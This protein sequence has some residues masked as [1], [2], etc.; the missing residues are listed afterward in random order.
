MSEALA[1]RDDQIALLQQCLRLINQL[2][3]EQYTHTNAPLYNS[4]I[5]PHLRHCIEHY[6]SFCNAWSSGQIN[7]DHRARSGD[8]ESTPSAA[9]DAIYSIIDALQKLQKDDLDQ[10]IKT[11][12]DCGTTGE[13]NFSLS[14]VRRELQF[15]TSHTVHHYALIAM[16]L[17]HQGI[18]PEKGFG[19]APS[20]LKFRSESS[21][22]AP[23]AG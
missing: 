7:Y 17:H 22:C 5:G 20:T 21:T 6:Q 10:G 15:L 3:P 8:I 18:T 11:C 13:E 9:T 12:M 14:S 16:I 23:S 4:G 19:I 1:I 2:T